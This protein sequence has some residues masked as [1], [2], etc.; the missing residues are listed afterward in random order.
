MSLKTGAEQC[1]D[2]DVDD[3]EEESDEEED[4]I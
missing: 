1:N 3:S 4:Q 2:L